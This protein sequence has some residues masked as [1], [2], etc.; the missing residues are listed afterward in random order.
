MLL[1]WFRCNMFY[2]TPDNIKVDLV[3]T[4]KCQASCEGSAVQRLYSKS[5]E[6]LDD[7][8]TGKGSG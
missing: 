4:A 3:H 5:F 1:R 8:I 2:T 7:R 6:Q